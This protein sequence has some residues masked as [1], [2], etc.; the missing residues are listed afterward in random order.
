MFKKLIVKIKENIEENNREN[1]TIGIN[2][3]ND[4]NKTNFKILNFLIPKIVNT[5]F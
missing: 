3:K 4:S 5:R 2:N 1:K